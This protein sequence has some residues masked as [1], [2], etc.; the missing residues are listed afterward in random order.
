MNGVAHTDIFATKGIEYLIV[1]LFLALLTVAWR[2]IR[3][4]VMAGEDAGDGRRDWRSVL[5]GVGLPET[6][7]LFHPGHAWARL[8]SGDDIATVGWDDFARRLVGPAEEFRL[9]EPGTMLQAGAPGWSVGAGGRELEMLA[10]VDGEVQAVNAAV[11]EDPTLASRDPYG[12]GWLMRVKV[13]SREPVRRNLLAGRLA[14]S[15]SELAERALQGIAAEAPDAALGAVLAD[16]G[17]PS[18]GLA[19]A[20]APDSWEEVVQRFFLLEPDIDTD[21]SNEEV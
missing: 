21:S 15:W 5:R 14:R 20:L 6:D 7:F 11:L 4:P 10:P 3:A 2:M 17:E 1:I 8:S 18:V 12:K 19:R 16:G 9:P 13:P